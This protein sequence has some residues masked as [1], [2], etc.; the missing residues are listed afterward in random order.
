[1]HDDGKPEPTHGAAPRPWLSE[2]LKAAVE[3]LHYSRR[4]QEDR[5]QR[6][7]RSI[8]SGEWL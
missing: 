5:L 8:V 7:K 6:V 1:M 2:S 3:T 4:T